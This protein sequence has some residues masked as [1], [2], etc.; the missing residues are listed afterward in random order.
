MQLTLSVHHLATAAL[1]ASLAS[2]STVLRRDPPGIN[3]AGK[4][5]G[6][7]CGAGSSCA[8]VFADTINKIPDDAKLSNGRPI[9]CMPDIMGSDGLCAFIY[10]MNGP[11]ET[12]N[13]A[14]I[15]RVAQ[16][17][18]NHCG[19]CG[20]APVHRD[21]GNRL[22]GGWLQIKRTDTGEICPTQGRGLG[23]CGH[24]TDGY[25]FQYDIPGVQP[26]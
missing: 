24:Y 8:Q 23:L 26:N 18:A 9:V 6:W 22:E 19:E 20:S 10:G 13:G 2:A 25:I 7:E 17:L 16:D 14:N 12:T 3:C 15:K 4:G 5:C 1:L 21:N 11:G